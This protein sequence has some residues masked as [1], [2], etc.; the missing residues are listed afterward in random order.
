VQS[1]HA[2]LR[3]GITTGPHCKE[4]YNEMNAFMTE[5]N[6]KFCVDVT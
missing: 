2:C 1:L 5:R 6:L 3:R 4:T